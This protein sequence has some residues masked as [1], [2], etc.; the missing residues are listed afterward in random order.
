MI[1]ITSGALE[2]LTTKL[3]SFNAGY[4]PFKIGIW[5]TTVGGEHGNVPLAREM[6]GVTFFFSDQRDGDFEQRYLLGE[7]GMVRIPD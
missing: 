2:A 4:G 1:V 6:T 5:T 7:G 3:D